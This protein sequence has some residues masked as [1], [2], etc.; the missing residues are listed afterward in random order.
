MRSLSD[1]DEMVKFTFPAGVPNS[2]HICEITEEAGSV[3]SDEV[4]VLAMG[5]MTLGIVW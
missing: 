2:I 5:M 3:I 4:T 1:N